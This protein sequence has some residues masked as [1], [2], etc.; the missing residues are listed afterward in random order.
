MDVTP[1]YDNSIVFPKTKLKY[2]YTQKWRDAQSELVARYGTAG[3]VYNSW[4]GYTEGMAAMP[5]KER[6][7]VD[8]QWLK[9]M[10][11]KLLGK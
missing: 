5:T 9:V 7:D 6:K 1:G 10:N 4:N 2:G 3:M 11:M 8:F